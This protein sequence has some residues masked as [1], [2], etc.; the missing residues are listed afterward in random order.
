MDDHLALLD[1]TAQAELIAGGEIT[2]REAVQAALARIEQLDPDLNAVIWSN[3]EQAMAAAEAIDGAG[4]HR[5]P[6]SGVPFLLKDIGATQAGLPY[7]LGNQALKAMDHRRTSDTELGARFRAAGFV[8]V[9]KSNLPELG[10]SPTTQP[11]SCGPTNNPWDLTRSPAGSSGGSAAAVAAGLV[12][13]AH[14]NDGGGSTRLPAAWCGLVGLKATRGRVPAPD[15][16]SRSVS[17]LVVSR[18]VRDTARVLDA[19]H[20]ATAADL[21]RAPVGPTGSYADELAQDPPPLRVALLTTAGRHEVDP[22]CVAAAEATARTLESAGHEVE[23]VGDEV[24][25]GEQ[26]EV[27]GRMW[28]AGIARRVDH[29]SDLAGRELTADDVEPYNW[30]AAERGRSM[31][32]TEWVAA[33]EEQQA[34]VVAVNRWLAPYDLLVTPTSAAVAMPTTELTPPPERPWRAARTYARIGAFTIA[35]NVT[36]HPAISLPLAQTD[37]GL[38]VGVQLV[39]GM[40]R[41][42]LLLRLAAGLEQSMPWAERRPPV[43]A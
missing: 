3:A 4:D 7:W 38:P 37:E 18:T 40:G 27:N 26:S 34:W 5:A 19:V 22:A 1:A 31:P 2:A 9:G 11:L 6:F 36:G 25:L 23:T 43:H 24:L 13:V 28:M 41:E 21:Y 35:F 17:E 20:G 12:P 16:I 8:T 39:A 29:L 42:D 33:E 10:S 30:T 14:A 32:A 15:V